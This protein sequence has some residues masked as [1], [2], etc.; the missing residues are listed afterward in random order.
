MNHPSATHTNTHAIADVERDTG[1]SKDTLRVWERRYGFPSPLRD[2]HGER[3]YGDD[4]LLRL[5]HI[6]RL[7]DAGYRPRH[8][9]ALPLAELLSVPVPLPA[10]GPQQAPKQPPRSVKIR[11]AAEPADTAPSQTQSAPLQRWMAMLRQHQLPELR[12]AFEQ[13]WMQHGLAS[14]V[15]DGIAPMNVW[16]GQAWLGGNL[17]VFEEHLYCETVQRVLRRAMGQLTAG[18][19]QKPPR[20]LLTTAPGEAHGL[21]LLMAECMLVLEGCDTV[22]LG[23]QTPLPDITHAARAY[24]AD[25]VA[26]GFSGATPPRDARKV[27]AQVRAQL[28]SHMALW[29]GGALPLLPARRAPTAA[30]PSPGPAGLGLHP[31]HRHMT[32]LAELSVA[33]DHWRA[34]QPQDKR[35]DRATTAAP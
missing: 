22:S 12:L 10:N 14:L 35:A 1:L 2:V 27:V 19:A 13:H 21:G 15:R 24:Q 3:L 4:Q 17:A 18:H 7:L 34:Q 28:P 9:V 31:G 32:D 11:A 23:V 26:L 33:V 16:V 5:R 25:V 20:V 8:V 6:R 30:H 29:T